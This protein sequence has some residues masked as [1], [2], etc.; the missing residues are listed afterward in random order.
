MTPAP[1]GKEP[2]FAEDFQLAFRRGEF[3]PRERALLLIG[4]V[5]GLRVSNLC[6]LV[7]ADVEFVPGGALLHV[8]RSKT[9][10]KGEGRAVFVPRTGGDNCPFAALKELPK[11]GDMFPIFGMGLTDDREVRKLVKRV[12]ELAGKDPHRV[13][14]HSLRKTAAT[15]ADQAGVPLEAIRDA[16]WHNKIETTRVYVKARAVAQNPTYAA[17]A[18]ALG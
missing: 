8:E 13:S 6:A 12:A 5:T 11:I 17:V 3:S 2:L 16:L 1:K 15:V 14:A 7:W 9:D 10:Q 4:I 18:R